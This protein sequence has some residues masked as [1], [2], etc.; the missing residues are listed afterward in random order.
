MGACLT[1]EGCVEAGGIELAALELAARD[2][3]SGVELARTRPGEDGSF[4]FDPLVA[5]EYEVV[6]LNAHG[7]AGFTRVERTGLVAAQPRR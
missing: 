3:A 5:R 4:R 1:L 6:L 2:P 7:L